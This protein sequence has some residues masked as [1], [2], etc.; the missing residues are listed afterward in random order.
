MQPRARLKAD[1]CSELIISCRGVLRARGQ[2][3][4][5]VAFSQAGVRGVDSPVWRRVP[6]RREVAK[7]SDMRFKSRQGLREYTGARL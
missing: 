7:S 1:L 5:R 6:G 3:E 2:V 4:G